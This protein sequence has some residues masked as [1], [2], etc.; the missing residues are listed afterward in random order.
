MVLGSEVTTEM[1][2]RGDTWGQGADTGL[3][4]KRLN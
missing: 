4:R 2:D 3:G 1:K